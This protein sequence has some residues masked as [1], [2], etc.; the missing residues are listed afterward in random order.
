[1]IIDATGERGEQGRFFGKGPDSSNA[2]LGGVAATR[3]PTGCET[4]Q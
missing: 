1:M 3:Y 2:V 4:W